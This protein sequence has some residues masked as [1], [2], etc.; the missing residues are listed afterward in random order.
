MQKED[1]ENADPVIES[2]DSKTLKKK[3]NGLGSRLAN[4][5]RRRRV[6]GDGSNACDG[7]L[8]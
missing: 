5:R 7:K 8:P 2:G 6:N 4:L 1:K 3:K